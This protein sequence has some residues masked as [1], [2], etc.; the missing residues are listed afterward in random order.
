[1]ND[2]N[3]EKLGWKKIK[4]SKFKLMYRD[5]EHGRMMMRA[6]YDLETD[7]LNLVTILN[8]DEFYADWVIFSLTKSQNPNCSSVTALSEPFKGIK[9]LRAI[10]KFPFLKAR[11]A[12]MFGQGW[13]KLD[14]NQTFTIDMSTVDQDDRGPN[15]LFRKDAEKES[16]E[17]QKVDKFLQKKED[18]KNGIIK[19]KTIPLSVHMFS[20]EFEIVKMNKFKMKVKFIF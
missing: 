20:F 2:K 8:E 7:I 12:V 18:E 19:A 5:D 17:I 16:E 14:M 1:M 6:E 3:T 10:F 11:E 15:I 4:N 9:L 13:N